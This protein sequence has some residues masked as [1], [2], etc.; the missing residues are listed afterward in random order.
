MTQKRYTSTYQSL[1]Y[2]VNQRVKTQKKSQ[3]PGPHYL[4]LVLPHLEKQ[5]CKNVSLFDNETKIKWQQNYRICRACER[6]IGNNEKKGTVC[7]VVSHSAR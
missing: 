3:T 7:Q 4:P 5:V 6:K 1:H 2:N